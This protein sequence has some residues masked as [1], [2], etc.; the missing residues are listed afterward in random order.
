MSFMVWYS[1]HNA[2]TFT[3]LWKRCGFSEFLCSSVTFNYF[4]WR[5]K[6]HIDF[7]DYSQKWIRSPRG[8]LRFRRVWK[9]KRHSPHWLLF[10]NLTTVREQCFTSKGIWH[11]TW[12]ILPYLEHNAYLHRVYSYW[13]NRRWSHWDTTDAA[14]ESVHAGEFP[15]HYNVDNFCASEIVT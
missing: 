2:V 6:F 5:V 3:G 13:A 7:K 8:T 11:V 4:F 14:V 10:A 1:V 12:L 9:T 15:L